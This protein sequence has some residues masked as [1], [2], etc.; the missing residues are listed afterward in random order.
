[1]MYLRQKI[2]AW[3]SRSVPDRAV[4]LAYDLPAVVLTTD[5]GLQRT[6]NQDRVAALSL[7][8]SNTDRLKVVAVA[9]GMGGMRDGAKCAT[10]AMASFFTALVSSHGQLQ[11]RAH[12]AISFA[13]DVVFKF[14]GGK[15]GATFSAV[16]LDISGTAL[17]VH[18]GDSRVYSFGQNSRVERLTKDDSLAEA[19]GGHGRELLQFVGMGPEMQPYIREVPSEVRNLAITSDGIHF[20]DA[21][22]LNSVLQNSSTIRSAA[23][24]LSALARWCGGP[25]NASGAFMDLA[26][27][28][29]DTDATSQV[30]AQIWDPNGSLSFNMGPDDYAELRVAPQNPAKRISGAEVKNPV[31]SNET[32]SS[33]PEVRGVTK[34]NTKR[35]KKDSPPKE[36]IQLEIKIEGN[37]GEDDGDHRQ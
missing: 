31:H 2:E 7:G 6:E 10:M 9:D 12:K 14:A 26:L 21:P 8:G 1:M 4:M 27:L 22:I 37:S 20:I 25:D 34:K 28:A 15:G 3:L 13:N 23:E 36:D 35:K 32:A 19:V 17:I 11:Q 33:G 24:R 29:Q 5:V 16:V 18:L 30:S